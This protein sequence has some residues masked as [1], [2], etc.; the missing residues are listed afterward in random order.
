M[1]K[2]STARMFFITELIIE[3]KTMS[4]GQIDQIRFAASFKALG[5]SACV[6]WH[7]WTCVEARGRPLVSFLTISLP[8]YFTPILRQGFL[9][10]L[11]LFSWLD[12]LACELPGP[13]CLTPWCWSH[14]HSLVYQLSHGCW[15]IKRSSLSLHR[16]LSLY[17]HWAISPTPKVLI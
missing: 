15:I 13:A 1:Q 9:L 16:E 2:D 4:H 10:N 11:R 7:T 14:W 12:R 17:I 3:K 6:Q 5:G 8:F